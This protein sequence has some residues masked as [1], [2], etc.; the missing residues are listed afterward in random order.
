MRMERTTVNGVRGKKSGQKSY[1]GSGGTLKETLCEISGSKI[2]ILMLKT[3]IR[4][5]KM[6]Y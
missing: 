6:R 1:L 4:M 5:W 2:A 3:S